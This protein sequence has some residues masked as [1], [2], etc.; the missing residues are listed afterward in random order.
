MQ[1]LITAAI[2]ISILVLCGFVLRWGITSGN[3]WVFAVMILG[4]IGLAIL[5]ADAEDKRDAKE[6][7]QKLT[8]FF[9]Q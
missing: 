5:V 9:R 8:A 2:T 4:G 7:W 1:K 3:Y 6:R